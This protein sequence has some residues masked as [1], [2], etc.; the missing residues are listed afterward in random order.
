MN[1]N[2]KEIY[3]KH[4]V[5]AQIKEYRKRNQINPAASNRV[6]NLQCCIAAGYLPLTA[7]AKCLQAATRLVVRGNKVAKH[8][9]KQR[10]EETKNKL[11][12]K[13]KEEN[14]KNKKSRTEG[15]CNDDRRDQD[16]PDKLHH[17]ILEK[18][19]G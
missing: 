15:E 17:P 16:P 3:R 6:S 1:K 10:K 9:F 19:A 14:R 11:K 8:R 5:K 4:N 2:E 18:N 13:E 7:V 12:N